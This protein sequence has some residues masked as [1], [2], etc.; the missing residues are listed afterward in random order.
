[1]PCEINLIDADDLRLVKISQEAQLG[2]SLY[3]MKR[4]KKYFFKKKRNPTDIEL[5]SLGQAWSEHCCY[6]CS[7]SILKKFIFGIDAPQN[8]LVI[9]ED[10]GVVEFDEDHAYVV[11]LESHNHPSAIEP[12]GGAATGI[13]GI[14][15]DVVC[16]GAQPIALIDPLF[17]GPLDS[18]TVPRGVKHPRY[19]FSGVVAGISDYGNRVGIPTVAG[20]VCFDEGYVGN[21]VV[22]VGCVGMVKKKH[23]VRSRV[24]KPGELLVLV[25]GKTGRDG[26]HGVTFASAEL[27]DSSEELRGAVQLGDPIAKEPLIHACVEVSEKGLLEGMKDLGGGGLSCVVG[28]MALAGGHGAEIELDRVPLKDA[29]MVPWEIWVSES[30]ERMMLS[31]DPKNLKEVLKIFEDWDVPATVIG[32]VIDEKIQRIFYAREKIFEMDMEFLIKGP[33]YNKPFQIKTVERKDA[34]FE[35]PEDYNEILLRLLASPNT[36]SKEWVIRQ[37]DHEVRAS[38]VIKPLQGVLGKNTHGDAVVIK[39]LEDSY[40]GLALT[41]G[42][43]PSYTK[44]DPF[45]GSAS[46]IDEVCRNLASVGATPHSFADCLNFGN[47]EKPDRLGEL[48]SSAEALGYVA[49]ALGTPF[50]SGNVSLYNEAP[51]GS[52]PPTP[53]I[54]GIGIVSDIRQCVTVDAKNEGNPVYLIGETKKEMGGSAYLK[55]LGIPSTTVPVVDPKALQ[56]RMGA[57]ISAI[58]NGFIASCHDVSEGGIAVCMAEMLIGGDVGARVDLGLI[59]NMRDDYKL[60]SESNTRWI[61]EVKRD[62]A[63]EFEKAF[64]GILFRIGEVGGNTLLIQNDD[65]TLIELSVKELRDAWSATLYDYMG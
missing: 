3:E 57:L 14:I 43:N 62:L 61:V 37:Y 21:C 27:T 11:A 26:I 24:K 12:Y 25:G 65:R 56:E 59:E 47:P 9:K 20:M 50:V 17:F 36:A 22:N 35:E 1:M 55:L 7:K 2:L 54:V 64:E 8:I 32:K 33:I 51:H 42:V 30:Q 39:P 53:T 58:R 29:G 15:R 45:W 10:A 49:K 48:H 18:S 60:F 40:R 52:I 5:Q 38:T 6:K 28:E 16:M 41:A 63:E 19:L 4:V 31:V 46:A 23:V 44:I 13:G 34:P